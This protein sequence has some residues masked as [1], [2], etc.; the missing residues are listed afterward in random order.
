MNSLSDKDRSQLNELGI[1][2]ETLEYQLTCFK[3]GIDPID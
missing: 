3:N 2:Q 1:S